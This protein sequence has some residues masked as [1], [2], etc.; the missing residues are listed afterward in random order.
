MQYFLWA[1]CRAKC[2][3]DSSSMCLH[4]EET[5]AGEGDKGVKGHKAEELKKWVPAACAPM[6]RVFL[7]QPHCLPKLTDSVIQIRC[8]NNT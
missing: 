6:C 8:G 4:R 3:S 1:R 7:Q 2:S 5:E